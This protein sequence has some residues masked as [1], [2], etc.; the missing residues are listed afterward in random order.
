MTYTVVMGKNSQTLYVRTGIFL[1]MGRACGPVACVEDLI[2]ESC[3]RL[4]SKSGAP[5]FLD[6][7][8][9]QAA[10]ELHHVLF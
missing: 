9:R 4:F 10:N 8:P 2:S 1:L 7:L 3:D 5:S 6:H